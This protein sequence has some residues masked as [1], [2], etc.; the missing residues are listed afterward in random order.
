MTAE[1]EIIA[2]WRDAGPPL[3]SIACITYNHEKY[4]AEAL[5]SFLAQRLEYPFEIVVHD[6]AS[7]DSTRSILEE[8]RDRF[9][10]IIKLVLQT[11]NQYSLGRRIFPILAEHCRGEFI[12]LC[13]GDD[14]WCETDKLQAQLACLRARPAVDICFHAARVISR[15]GRKL[16]R[17][18]PAGADRLFSLNQVIA[19][20][21]E[22][23]PTSS[24][25]V[26]AD[27][28]RRLPGWIDA[29]PVGD[30]F[31]QVYGAL[32]GAVY[33]NREMSCYR[34]RTEASWSADV[35]SSFVRLKA[36]ADK[37]LH[38]LKL[39]EDD[40]KSNSLSVTHI[41]R[42]R[43]RVVFALLVYSL[44]NRYLPGLFESAKLS[45]TVKK[46]DLARLTAAYLG[47]RT[48]IFIRT[49]LGKFLA[50]K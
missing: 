50:A 24:L 19:G 5:N 22:F 7:T 32:N 28:F 15:E 48:G 30:Y 9:P 14:Y 40:F 4:I 29:A 39:L 1:K 18:A 37:M 45:S 26:R 2:R 3:V 6:D 12:A 47:E 17:M 25:F 31:I 46:V 23:M 20:G 21:G 33:L 41:P 11:R 16:R 27:V 38:S 13:E 8:Y 44:K 34:Q 35:D 43:A 49:L 10:R 36:F 42:M